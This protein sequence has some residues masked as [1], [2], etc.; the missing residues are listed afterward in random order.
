[1]TDAIEAK[2]DKLDQRLEKIE[3]TI[4]TIAVQNERITNL[5]SQMNALWR[6]C[7]EQTKTNLEFEKHK[8][9][10][11]RVQIAR[12]WW[13][14]GIMITAELTVIGLGFQVVR[15]MVQ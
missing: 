11:P 6:K 1:M 9:S 2:I 3:V 8:A 5:Q 4:Q 12:I 10:C 14:I 13:A 15:T 7:D